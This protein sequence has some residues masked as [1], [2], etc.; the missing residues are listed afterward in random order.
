MKRSLIVIAHDLIACICCFL[1][2]VYLRLGEIH[3]DAPFLKQ[4]VLFFFL[5]CLIS[6]VLLRLHRSIWLYTSTHD[7]VRI[8]QAV[9]L[10]V[11]LFLPVMFIYS[12]L[13]GFPRSVVVI[14]WLLLVMWLGG[15]RLAYRLYRDRSFSLLKSDTRTPV[16]LVGA[17]EN[18]ALFIRES[19]SRE[20]SPYRPIALLDPSEKRVGRV[21]HN[22]K[23]YGT[24]R[25]IEDAFKQLEKEK[26]YV[27]RILISHGRYQGEDIQTI[28]DFAKAHGLPVSKLPRMSDFSE[29][30]NAIEVKPVAIED[31]LGRMPRTPQLGR[32]S[33]LIRDKCVIVTGAGGTI[34]G[35]L[36]KQI[37]EES[38]R[39]IILYELSEYL[40]YKIEQYLRNHYPTI[41]MIGIVGD[42]RSA[43]QLD[44]V[45]KTHKPQLV[46]HAAALKHVPIVEDNAIEAALTNIIGTQR[47]ADAALLY[48]AE[49]MVMISTDK[50]VN[51]SSFMGVTKRVAE[52]YVHSLSRKKNS[53]N[54]LFATVRFGNVLGSSG[55]VIPLFQQ[56]IEQGG[57]IT[58]THPE[59]TRYFMTI[60]EAVELVLQASTIE[61]KDNNEER[62]AIYVLD[63]GEPIRITDLAL[64]MIKLAGLEPEKDITIAYTGIRPGEKLHEELFY[65]DEVKEP[66]RYEGIFNAHTASP[67]YRKMQ[68]Y[69]DK[70]ARFCIKR[71]QEGLRAIAKE[72][73]PSYQS[74]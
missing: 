71:D 3:W 18:A 13:E 37:A 61:H 43:E 42:V 74:E 72:I 59:M 51:P 10:A 36:V 63:M 9:T 40:L 39:K 48:G 21:F 16:L 5:S 1:L 6:F 23:I 15:V 12:R 7:L 17:N 26:L 33:E 49:R 30:A 54:T 2:A 50:V 11:L 25:H 65:P 22:L 32:R 69:L 41:E 14:V 44:E 56:Q 46:F 68:K 53:Q 52:R 55:S 27:Q 58:V 70:I 45:F 47:V 64:Q 28:V 19:Q 20:R 29:Q 62:S 8:I 57:P 38:P 60:S 31:V 73:V 34:G 4:G 67:D 35:E 66:T 24:L